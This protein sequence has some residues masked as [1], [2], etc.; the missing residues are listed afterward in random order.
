VNF[1]C[2]W[3]FFIRQFRSKC[4]WWL[5][6]MANSSEAIWVAVRSRLSLMRSVMVPPSPWCT[7]IAKI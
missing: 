6:T 7:R 1:D 3:D 4:W 2:A 5:A